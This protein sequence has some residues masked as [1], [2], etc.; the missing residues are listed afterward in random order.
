[1]K[2]LFREVKNKMKKN[3]CLS[4]EMQ[5]ESCRF[6]LGQI[7]ESAGAIGSNSGQQ[8]GIYTELHAHF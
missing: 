8:S 4:L 3:L 2:D 6:H 7:H 1:M 5:K